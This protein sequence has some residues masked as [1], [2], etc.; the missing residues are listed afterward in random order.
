MTMTDH[1]DCRCLAEAPTHPDAVEERVIG[2]DPSHGRFAAV[3]LVRCAR[4]NRLWLRY[5]VEYEHLTAAGRWGAA[6]D[7]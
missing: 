5:A 6:S 7:R 3:T 2:T 1:P 4:C